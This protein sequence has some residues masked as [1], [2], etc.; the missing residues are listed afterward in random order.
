MNNNSASISNVN[1]INV[2]LPVSPALTTSPNSN[3][4]SHANVPQRQQ[5]SSNFSNLSAGMNAI[6]VSSNLNS[7][8]AKSGLSNCIVSMSDD[9]ETKSDNKITDNGLNNDSNINMDDLD[10]LKFDI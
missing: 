3:L 1:N 2:G 6:R 7:A 9:G 5:K 4:Q 8:N 10:W